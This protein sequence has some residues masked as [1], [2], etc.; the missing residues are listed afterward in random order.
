MNEFSAAIKYDDHALHLNNRGLAYYH[1]G[2]LDKAKEDFDE[3]LKRSSQDPYFYFNRGNVYLDQG[4]FELAQQ[5]YDRAI[6]INPQNPKFWHS[7]GLSYEGTKDQE[8]Y[9]KAIEMYKRALEHQENY[10]TSRFHLG[11]MYHKMNMFN[12]ALSCYSYVISKLSDDKTIYVKRG[13]V[14]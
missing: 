11:G 6:D 3:A 13:L 8:H 12:E 2:E 9:P 10:L 7:K 1:I 14:Y 4:N 5:D